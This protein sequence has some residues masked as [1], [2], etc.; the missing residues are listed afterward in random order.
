MS[1]IRFAFLSLAAVT[2]MGVSQS[3]ATAGG[4]TDLFRSPVQ[5]VS[6][7]VPFL[8][9]STAIP[10]DNE[11]MAMPSPNSQRLTEY[12]VDVVRYGFNV[13]PTARI[14]RQNGLMPFSF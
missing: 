6:P 12:P 5:M 8:D 14:L 11:L 4:F 13:Y 2:V 10:S 7:L 3:T 1:K 9:V